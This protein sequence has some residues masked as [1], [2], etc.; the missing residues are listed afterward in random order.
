M[1]QSQLSAVAH[2]QD[3]APFHPSCFVCGSGNTRGLGVRFEAQAGG[4]VRGV[5]QCDACYQGYSGWLHGGV[6]AT[7]L[8]AAMAHCLHSL[9]VDAVTARLS[10]NYRQPVKVD[11]TALVRAHLVA[12]DAP[13]YRVDSVLVQEGEVRASACGTF[14][15]KE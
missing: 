4:S 2:P 12:N 8:D 13:L 14:V 1:T 11:R 3:T 5:F 6:I 10:V 9:G 15:K 7:L